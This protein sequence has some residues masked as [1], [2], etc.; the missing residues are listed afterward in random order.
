MGG[1]WH[2]TRRFFGAVRPGAPAADDERWALDHLGS[3]EAGIWNL[4][5]NPDRRHAIAV[6]K[7]VVDDERLADEEP[8]QAV[9]AAALLHDCGKVVCRMRTPAR[10]VATMVW[11]VAPDDQADRWLDSAG[12]FRLRLAQYRRHPVIGA[13]LLQRAGADPLTWQWA[14]Q[15]HLP[16]RRWTVPVEIG[17]VLRDCDDD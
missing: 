13:E 6:A 2:L 3:G 5:N 4:M 7:A 16:E 12:G 9:V 15:H 11:A 1:V 14:A 8:E 17:R 10:V